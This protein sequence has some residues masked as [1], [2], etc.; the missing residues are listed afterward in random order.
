LLKI[1]IG[2]LNVWQVNE[3]QAQKGNSAFQF[4]L[5][6][7][8]YF[9]QF[10]PFLIFLNWDKRRY[11]IHQMAHMESLANVK[12]LIVS[13]GTTYHF[14]KIIICVGNHAVNYKN[15]A[16]NFNHAMNYKNIEVNHVVNHVTFLFLIFCNIKT[17]LK[18][19]DYCFAKQA[20]IIL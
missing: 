19:L 5:M 2:Y 20:L 4:K 14:T 11:D 12:A 7:L 10:M 3:T 1:S 17:T 16:V 9:M 8:G 13:I 6:A 15:T 18:W